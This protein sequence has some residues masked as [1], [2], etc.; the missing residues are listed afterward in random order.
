VL[1]QLHVRSGL[2]KYLVVHA[3]CVELQ[4]QTKAFLA[5]QLPRTN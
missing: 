3:L 2:K 5:S 1:A 4:P